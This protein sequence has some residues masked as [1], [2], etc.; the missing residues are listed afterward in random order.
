MSATDTPAA[1]ATLRTTTG[2][3]AARWVAAHCREVPWLT[4]TAI[5]TTVA[6]AALQVLPLLLLGR[7]VDAVVAGGPRSVLVTTGVWMAG[8]P[9]GGRGPPPPATPT[10]RRGQPRAPS[11]RPGRARSARG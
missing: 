7:V 11:P 5:L 9:R 3:E 4:A 2:R 8:G 6:G 10:R 1:Q